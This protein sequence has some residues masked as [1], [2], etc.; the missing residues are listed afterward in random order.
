MRVTLGLLMVGWLV[1]QPALPTLEAQSVA[2]EPAVT[3]DSLAVT[4]DSLAVAVPFGPGERMEYQVKLGIF[5][6]G[7]AYIAVDGLDTVRGHPTYRLS[8]GSRVASCSPR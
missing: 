7:E 2:E 6:A 5:S 3:Q 4:Q 8:M 1:L